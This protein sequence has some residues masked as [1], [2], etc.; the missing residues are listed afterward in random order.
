LS[1]FKELLVDHS[2]IYIEALGIKGFFFDIRGKVGVTGNSKKRHFF[3]RI[4][5]TSISTRTFKIDHQQRV[6]KTATGSL[7]LTMI[8][9]Y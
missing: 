2:Y 1:L 9:S 7:G 8:L 5:K 3:F 6:V 4:G